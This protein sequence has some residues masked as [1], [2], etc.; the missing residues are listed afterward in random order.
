MK[1]VSTFS[2]ILTVIAVI[3]IGW[4]VFTYKDR[5]ANPINTTGEVAP[6]PTASWPSVEVDKRT[7]SDENQ[8]YTIDVTYPVTKDVAINDKFKAFVEDQIAQF[9]EDTAWVLDPAIESA[10]EATLS[11]TIDYREERSTHAD[12][13]I[14]TIST[15]TGGAHGLQI[16][17]TFAF[18]AVGTSIMQGDLFANPDTGLKAVATFVQKEIEKKKISDAE[19]IKDGAGATPDNYQ[20]FI[21]SDAGVTFIFDPYQVAPYAAGTQNILV[22]FTVFKANPKLTQ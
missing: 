9:K 19:W 5:Q 6:S 7:I 4:V 21:I 2:I 15:Y 1:P 12:N 16:T 10:A 18:D 8:Y 11:L 17:K 14:F 13:Y 3:G 22:P 20:S